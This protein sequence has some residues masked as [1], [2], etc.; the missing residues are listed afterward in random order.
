LIQ[1]G[2][3]NFYGTTC[4]GGSSGDGTIF[5]VS[6]AGEFSSLYSFTEAN[7][8]GDPNS[9]LIQTDYESFLGT[10]Q[11]ALASQSGSVYEFIPSTMLPAPVQIEL[12]PPSVSY[13]SPA[14]INWYVLNAF[15]LTMQQCYAFV[16]NNDSGAGPWIGKQ[17]GT[18]NASTQLFSGSSS[19]TATAA[20]THT[21]SLTCGGQESGFATLLVTKAETEIALTATPNPATVGQNVTLKATVTGSASTPSGTVTFKYGTDTLA[22]KTLSNGTA[23]FTASTSGLPPGAYKLTTTYSGNSNYNPSTSPTYTVTLDKAQTGRD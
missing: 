5:Q 11:G 9:S 19:V 15:S 18:Y 1:G 2:D 20:G 17:T 21:Y 6:S 8:D 12:S 22:T 10:A 7:G 3:G 13:G 4:C 14:T 23:S 16:P